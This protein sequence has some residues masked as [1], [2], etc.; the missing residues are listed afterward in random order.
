MDWVGVPEDWVRKQCS[1]KLNY[2]VKYSLIPTQRA[3]M[4]F[5]APTL[6]LSPDFKAFHSLPSHI[7]KR[8]EVTPEKS[9]P[10]KLSCFFY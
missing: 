10:L 5:H 7:D 9:L 2:S 3:E 8:R 4:Q 1:A 6:V